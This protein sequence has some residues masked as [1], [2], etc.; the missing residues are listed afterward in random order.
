MSANTLTRKP[1][2]IA[3]LIGV[4]SLL[5]IVVIAGCTA[6]A[7]DKNKPALAAAAVRATPV[8]AMIIKAATL[9]EELK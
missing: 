9:K 5:I 6:G 7:K 2:V 4:V 8:D 3:Q 1:S